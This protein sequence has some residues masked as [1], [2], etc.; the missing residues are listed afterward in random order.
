MMIYTNSTVN[1]FLKESLEFAAFEGLSLKG[2]PEGT[3]KVE[4]KIGPNE[5]KVIEIE[6][7]TG[8]GGYS[9]ATKCACSI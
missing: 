9:F 2:Y 7:I 4:I 8:S 3:R 5:E 1:K 6:I